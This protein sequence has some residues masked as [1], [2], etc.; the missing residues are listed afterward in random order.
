MRCVHW[1]H[2]W[3]VMFVRPSEC[4]IFWTTNQPINYLT[5]LLTY[6]LIYL[7]TY[8]MKQSP[9]EADSHLSCQGNP[10]LLYRTR[11]FFTVIIRAPKSEAL[12]NVSWQAGF[13]RKGIVS[14]S[15][16]PQAGGPTLICCPRLLLLFRYIEH[17]QLHSVTGSRVL[18]PQPEDPPCRG[19]RGSIDIDETQKWGL[20]Y[21][22]WGRINFALC[23]LYINPTSYEAQTELTNFLKNVCST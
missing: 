10:P 18:N 1:T 15:L 7:L 17:S 22:L 14:P 6:L 16:N 8:V 4:I 5:N 19:D 3:D 9:S 21:K 13:L 12:F 2:K 11:R 23:Q 20:H